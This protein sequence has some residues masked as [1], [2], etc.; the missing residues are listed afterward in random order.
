MEILTKKVNHTIPTRWDEIKLS[1]Y[2]KYYR[3]IK[4][5]SPDDEFYNEEVL[6]KFAH[7]ICLLH[8]NLFPA[9]EATTVAEIGENMTRMFKQTATMPL[10]SKF[11]IGDVKYGFIPNLQDLTYG[12]YVDLTLYGQKLW[13]ED[14]VYKFLSI[15]YRPIKK[16]NGDEYQLDD[17]SGTSTIRIDLF[18]THVTCDVVWGA[19]SFFLLL[20]LALVNSTT[21]YLTDLTQEIQQELKQILQTN[22]EHI[23]QSIH[24]LEG[25][26]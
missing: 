12:E 16:E 7:Y 10:V 21:F 3:S 5:L 11:S 8:E 13:D 17:Y 15:L 20:Q 24:W 18:K 2:L 22:G 1:L 6:K 23:K 19:I 14:N 26:S 9:L 25:D 4:D